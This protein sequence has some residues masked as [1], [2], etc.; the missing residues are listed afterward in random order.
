MGRFLRFDL[1][2]IFFSGRTVV[3][4]IVVPLI[5]MLLFTT[6]VAPLLVTRSRVAASCFAIYNEDGTQVSKDF[7][8]FVASSESFEGIVYLF[9]VNSLEEGLG[10]VKTGEASGL[11]HI[12]PGLYDDMLNGK[13]V[14]C[15]IY[16]ADMHILECS[17]VQTAIETA[18]NTAGGAQNG[19]YA[20]RDD[21]LKLGASTE[22]ADGLYE[23]M[24][25]CGINVITNRRA[26][27]G[28]DGFISPVGGYLPAE[29]YLSAMLTWFLALAILPL[30]GFSAG[31]FSMSVLQRGMK[32]R[33][34]RLKFLSARLI[35]G[36][37]FLLAVMLM[38][39]PIGIVSSSLDR[40]F[41]G[42]IAALF[43]S[44]GFMALCFSALALGISAWMPNR[45]A[46]MWLGFWLVIAFSLLGGT[47]A[48]ESMLP[49]W[50]RNLGLWS[51]V[52]SAMRLLS[53]GIF[54]FDAAV[55]RVDMLKTGL[56]GMIGC[57]MAAAGFMRKA[58]R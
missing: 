58:V 25:D 53:T 34:M 18:L 49:G 4:C 54:N 32:T 1:K 22:G 14:S 11:L 24:M 36:A 51:P 17:L 8:D 41:H 42:N 12:P 38:V 55:Y 9:N 40:L 52:R 48:P 57:V 7:I 2:R 50:V 13:D 35:S 27:L 16:G 19:L 20:L 26:I 5:V 33:A 28:E 45:D 21:V 3:L 43:L 39:F 15:D 10:L 6:V 31:D 37:L 44:M 56:W 30:A 29:F 47:A 46:A 23:S